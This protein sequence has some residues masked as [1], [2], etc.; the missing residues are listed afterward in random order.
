MTTIIDLGYFSKPEPSNEKEAHEIANFALFQLDRIKYMADKNDPAKTATMLDGLDRV[1]ELFPEP[2]KL[3]DFSSVNNGDGIYRIVQG[4]SY[5][6]FD[7][8]REYGYLATE[9]VNNES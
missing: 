8:R 4:E 5:V 7:F 6:W 9:E 2:F 3:Y 1:K